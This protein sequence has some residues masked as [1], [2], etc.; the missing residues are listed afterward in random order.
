MSTTFKCPHC[1]AP[2]QYDGGQQIVIKC[3]HCGMSSAVPADLRPAQPN[4]GKST[5]FISPEAIFKINELLAKNNKIEA[6]KVLRGATG[7]GLKE[8][9][10]VVDAFQNDD[11][12]VLNE[13]LMMISSG[14]TINVNLSGAGKAAGTAAGVG[15]IGTLISIGV[16]LAVIGG[17]AW[18]VMRQINGA[19]NL[20]STNGVTINTNLDPIRQ[21]INAVTSP[22]DGLSLRENAALISVD[23]KAMPDV[24]G[25]GYDIK[26]SKNALVYIDPISKTLRW[27][28]DADLQ[29]KFLPTLDTVYLAD[30]TRLL[31]LDRATGTTRW[32]TSLSDEV[33]G[34]CNECI[35]LV[36]NGDTA[37]V[38]V[39]TKDDVLQA[40]DVKSGKKVWSQTLSNVLPRFFV[41]GEKIVAIDRHEKTDGLPA[42]VTVF[43]ANGDAL[44]NFDVTCKLKGASGSSNIYAQ[45]YDAM[46]LDEAT[47]VLYAW[48]GTFDGCAQ[49]WDLSTGKALWTTT[50]LDAQPPEYDAASFVL[51][52]DKIYVGGDDQVV[53][54]DAATGK[55]RNL[56]PKSEDYAKL[57]PLGE[58]D[59]VLVVRAVRT[60]GTPRFELWGIDTTTGNKLW[61]VKFGE[62]GPMQG[63]GPEALVGL[64]GKDRE[65]VAWTAQ[66]TPAGLVL[67]RNA[68]KPEF[69]LSVETLNVKDGTS[70]GQKSIKLNVSSPFYSV[71]AVLGWRGDVAWLHLNNSYYAVDVR[72]VEIVQK[73]P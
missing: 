59:G 56:V 70:Q 35:R 61:D 48:Y 8:S 33:T 34:V 40:F 50:I 20:F 69:Q 47:G 42:Q 39:L 13:K 17:V 67:V 65:D 43:S 22:F 53:A 46:K 7:L 38:V 29:S 58:Q 62:G 1:G 12:D 10:D 14:P 37:R 36:A 2:L 15:C 55:A 72:K 52:D 44:L 27:R 9:K 3:D 25:L 21:A 30:K 26:T 41:W 68:G 16:V 28:V 19:G 63:N 54:L 31:A 66:L 49:K 18:F 23:D 71:P 24:L 60:R 6:I 5:G 45:P 57:R 11:V 64:I 51:R 32:Q 4:G 73:I